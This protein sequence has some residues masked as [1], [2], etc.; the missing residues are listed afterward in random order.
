MTADY[1]LACAAYKAAVDA[2]KVARAKCAASGIDGSY[3]IARAAFNVASDKFDRAF[4][5]ELATL[6]DEMLVMD[7][8]RLLARPTGPGS[9]L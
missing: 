5:A 2:L 4:A 8:A 9:L 7:A 6:P 3:L 1:I